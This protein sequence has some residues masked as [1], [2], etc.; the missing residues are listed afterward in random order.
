MSKF[1]LWVFQLLFPF[2]STK[3]KKLLFPL[4]HFLMCISFYGS[5]VLE[6]HPFYLPH[7]ECCLFVDL[8]ILCHQGIR[9]AFT[10]MILHFQRLSIARIPPKIANEPKSKDPPRGLIFQRKGMGLRSKDPSITT[11][12]NEAI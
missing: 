10:M 1:T 11:V 4:F 2:L 5:T 8:L 12:K 3:K 7:Y 6:I 9:K